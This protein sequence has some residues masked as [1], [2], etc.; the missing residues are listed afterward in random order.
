MIHS[1]FANPP[2]AEKEYKTWCDSYTW[3][4][5]DEIVKNMLDSRAESQN[6]IH[7]IVQ[8]K[9]TQQCPLRKQSFQLGALRKQSFQLG[10]LL[11]LLPL[12][13]YDKNNYTPHSQD[14][15]SQINFREIMASEVLPGSKTSLHPNTKKHVKVQPPEKSNSTY[16][17][18]PSSTFGFK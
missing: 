6:K 9:L 5:R 7:K 18:I 8:D 15:L 12:T 2:E 1:Y 11:P 14:T 17:D 10:A 16:F 3:Y 13:I 4:G